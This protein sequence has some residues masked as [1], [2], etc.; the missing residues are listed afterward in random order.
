MKVIANV[1]MV[2]LLVRGD[3]SDL[4]ALLVRNWQKSRLSARLLVIFVTN[5]IN[6]RAA[7][8]ALA[9]K[10]NSLVLRLNDLDRK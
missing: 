7:N 9:V 8:S 1:L 10:E 3:F 2:I 6:M 5:R 4:L